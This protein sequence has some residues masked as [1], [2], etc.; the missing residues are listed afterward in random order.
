MSKN[1]KETIAEGI[2]KSKELREHFDG[3]TTLQLRQFFKSTKA[4]ALKKILRNLIW[5]M[6]QNTTQEDKETENQIK[7]LQQ[8]LVMNKKRREGRDKQL[9][10]YL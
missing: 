7:E 10:K 3:M 1:N 9:E 5:A 6:D 8:R 4:E 2:K